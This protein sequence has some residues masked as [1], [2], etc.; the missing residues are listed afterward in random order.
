MAGNLT[1]PISVF[2][3]VN[4]DYNPKLLD[5][6]NF[7]RLCVIGSSTNTRGT[8][9]GVYSS[10]EGVA[11]HYAITTNEYKIAQKLFMQVPRPRSIMIATVT[12]IV[13]T[14]AA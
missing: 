6:N 3:N 14:P 13:Y 8:D 7:N 1:L 9:T 11:Q 12:G 4:T 10:L 5:K 2:V